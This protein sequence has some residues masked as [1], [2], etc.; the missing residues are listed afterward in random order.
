MANKKQ[1]YDATSNP[2]NPYQSHVVKASAG[3]GKTFQLS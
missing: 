3:C 1:I 2:R